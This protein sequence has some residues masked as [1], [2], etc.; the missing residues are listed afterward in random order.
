MAERKEP[1]VVWYKDGLI[2]I[3]P[4][5]SETVYFTDYSDEMFKLINGVRWTVTNKGYLRGY[6]NG[7]NISLH[8]LVLPKEEGIHS[9]HINR[10]KEDNRRCNLRNVTPTENFVNRGLTI[11]N[12]SGYLGVS[13]NIKSKKWMA[14]IRVNKKSKNLGYYDDPEEAHEVFK[15]AAEKYYPGIVYPEDIQSSEVK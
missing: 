3:L 5:N 9:D 12:T 14:S 1:A 13:W 6:I 7:K 8:H 15:R 2:K 10:K 4:V 11:R